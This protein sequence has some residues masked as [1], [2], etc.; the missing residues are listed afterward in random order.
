MLFRRN[1]RISHLIVVD[2]YSSSELVNNKS[3]WDS[4][5]EKFN[6][7][8]DESQVLMET[9]AEIVLTMLTNKHVKV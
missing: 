1:R 3:L 4:R 6:F 7:W 5:L 2:E 8:R 9:K